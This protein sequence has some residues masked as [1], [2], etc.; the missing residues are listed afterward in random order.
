VTRIPNLFLASD[1]VRTFTDLATMEAANEAAR[2]AVNGI[3][4]AAGSAEPRCGIWDLY[5]PEIFMPWRQ[6]DA[7]RFAQGLPWD[8]A[9]VKVGLSV[10]SMVDRAIV[11]LEHASDVHTVFGA[12]EGTA[13]D[14]LKNQAA[15]FIDRNA[16]GPV[17][18]LRR[19]ATSVIERIGQLVAARIAEAQGHGLVPAPGGVTAV[20]PSQPAAS[21]RSGRV[22]IVP[23]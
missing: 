4:D 16:P 6:M 5:E 20:G 17:S 10:A 3:L 19:D 14:L 18:E 1:Y 2:R 13:L 12:P 15:A 8:D 21:V 23:H 22:E 7:V 9:M 11:A